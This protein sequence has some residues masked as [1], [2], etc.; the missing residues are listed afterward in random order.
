MSEGVRDEFWG[1]A[2]IATVYAVIGLVWV[3]ISDNTLLFLVSGVGDLTKLQTLKE[4][5]FVVGSAVL[6]Y[7]LLCL[8]AAKTRQLQAFYKG[9]LRP[10]SQFYWFADRNGQSLQLSE[11]FE[12]FTGIHPA[13]VGNDPWADL[14][15]LNDVDSFLRRRRE[16]QETGTGFET[17]FRLQGRD[18]DYRYVLYREMPV[19]DRQGAVCQWVGS[20]T[21][22][23]HYRLMEKHLRDHQQDLRLAEEVAGISLWRWS[24]HSG[25]VVFSTTMSNQLGYSADG[26]PKTVEKFYELVHPDD[27]ALIKADIENAIAGRPVDQRSFRLRHV[28]G[29][30]RWI[31]SR[32]IAECDETGKIVGLCGANIDITEQKRNEEQLDRLASRD[33]ITGFL[34]WR[35]MHEVLADAIEAAVAE[36]NSVGL[37]YVDIDHF[38]IINQSMGYEA[39][40]AL[41]AEAGRRL[42]ACI[43]GSDALCRH[44]GDRFAV[45]VTGNPT[46][47]RILAI[48]HTIKRAFENAFRLDGEELFVTVT[49]GASRFQHNARDAASLINQTDTAMLKGKE[50]GRNCIVLYT[51]DMAVDAQRWLSYKSA[52]QY[53]LKHDEFSV[54]FQPQLDLRTG[55]YSVFEALARWRSRRFGEVPPA[56][57]IPIAEQSGLIDELGNRIFS[58]AVAQLA[59]WRKLG[60]HHVR[61]CINLSVKQLYEPDF[62]A[63]VR[64]LTAAAEVPPECI[65]LE[66]T[67]STIMENVPYAC[68]VIRQLS[69]LGFTVAIDDF[70]TGYSSLSYL[71]CLP[72]DV[73]KIDRAFIEDIEH[74]SSGAKIAKA[75]IALAHSLDMRVVAEG[76]ETGAQLDFVQRH[77]CDA[78]QGYYFSEPVAPMSAVAFLTRQGPN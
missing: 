35:K 64:Q 61:I 58:Q 41:L 16:A 59:Q 38:K 54:V 32:L 23:T 26:L 8:F 31:L 18:G 46:E 63:T 29:S 22:I 37:L 78:A 73:L 12:A 72:A 51:P 15:H 9:L 50:K 39:G 69:R 66:I 28:D 71:S 49:I 30:Y 53:G 57:F 36:H 6:L 7:W 3:S 77:G 14:V 74:E 33:E 65:E 2:G 27:L 60:L 13:T 20:C 67:E 42:E 45:I 21:D 70:G 19:F 75:V 68:A 10:A 44:N 48:A 24:L 11:G 62:I 5:M 52:M 56:V 25:D 55:T 76:V 17:R 1:P 43:E 4:W 47:R 34:N 40:D